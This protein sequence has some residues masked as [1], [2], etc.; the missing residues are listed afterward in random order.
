MTLLKPISQKQAIITISDLP[1]I[2]ITSISGGQATR[3]KVEFNNGQDGITRTMPGFTKYEPLNLTKTFSPEND[4]KL[5]EWLEKQNVNPAPFNIA[6]QPVQAD[7]ANTPVPGSKQILYS[8]C[9]VS[10]YKLPEFDRNSTGLAIIEF[11]I[12]FN[13]APS[14]Q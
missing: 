8:N 4:A 10:S 9:F 2:F 11:E 7:I 13:E 12:V 1:D 14:L 6:I 3:E 5:V